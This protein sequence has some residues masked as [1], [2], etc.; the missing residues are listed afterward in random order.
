MIFYRATGKS[1]LDNTPVSDEMVKAMTRGE[2]VGKEL[3]VSLNVNCMDERS[4]GKYAWD[5]PL[6]H[7]CVFRVFL[8]QP[9]WSA[10]RVREIQEIG[11]LL[12]SCPRSVIAKNKQIMQT[13]CNSLMFDF[14]RFP[15]SA[16]HWMRFF[17]HCHFP[18]N[19]LEVYLGTHS[20]VSALN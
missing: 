19:K 8:L 9:F 17:I 6:F 3:K 18:R 15:D 2:F 12:K 16:L 5:K 20:N 13:S 11:K 10:P 1:P 4:D 14:R 7:P